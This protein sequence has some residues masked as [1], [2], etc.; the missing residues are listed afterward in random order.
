MLTDQFGCQGLELQ[1]LWIMNPLEKVCRLRLQGVPILRI[2]SGGSTGF[3]HQS[4][5]HDF[6]ASVGD[7]A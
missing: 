4:G 7:I 6:I 5:R 3:F 2:T 1:H